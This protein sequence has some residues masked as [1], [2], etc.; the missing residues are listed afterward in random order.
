MLLQQSWPPSKVIVSERI[1]T[2]QFLLRWWLVCLT[3]CTLDT[4]PL[5]AEIPVGP[6]FGCVLVS[7][8]RCCGGCCCCL[9]FVLL[10]C[11]LLLL[12][13]L[14]LVCPCLRFVLP[15]PSGMYALLPCPFAQPGSCC[16]P[17]SV[18]TS[19]QLCKA[20]VPALWEPG[21]WGSALAGPYLRLFCPCLQCALTVGRP[22]YTLSL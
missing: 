6:L 9:C 2:M 20:H 12:L 1:N 19:L 3:D 22:E 18:S 21:P 16:G 17:Y 13:L 10:S 4:V 5:D 11:V 7:C 8:S 14:L 15:A